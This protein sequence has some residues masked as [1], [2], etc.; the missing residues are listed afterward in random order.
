[1]Q[2]SSSPTG[3]VWKRERGTKVASS[4]FHGWKHEPFRSLQAIL[5]HIVTD[6]RLGRGGNHIQSMTV[7]PILPCNCLLLQSLFLSTHCLLP[8]GPPFCGLVFFQ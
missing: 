3:R 6:N 1:M 7:L 4:G 5:I 8:S 2:I